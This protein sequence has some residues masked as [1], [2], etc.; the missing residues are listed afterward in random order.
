MAFEFVA[1]NGIIALNNTTITGS[2][3]TTGT[4]TS[5]ALIRSGST[6]LQI[7][8]G[9]GSVITAGTNI[10]I[11]GGT[12]SATG[13]GGGGGGISGSGVSGQLTYW[14]GTTSVTGSTTLTYSPTGALGL[15]ISPT[16]TAATNLARG[17]YLNPNLTIAAN[18]DVIVGL[19]ITP[20]YIGNVGTVNIINSGASYTAGTYTSV[21]LTGGNGTGAIATIVIAGGSIT[22]VTITAS[23]SG[24]YLG[25]VLSASSA[26][27]G[28]TGTGFSTSVA[29]FAYTGTSNYA[30]RIKGNQL[31]TSNS[32]YTTYNTTPS[33]RL[34]GISS[35]TNQ[36]ALSVWSNG[37]LAV[38]I[39]ASAASNVNG[40]VIYADNGF[41]APSYFSN[42]DSRGLKLNDGTATMLFQRTNTSGQI[43]IGISTYTSTLG[44]ANAAASPATNIKQYDTYILGSNYVPT[45]TINDIALYVNQPAGGL[46]IRI[47]GNTGNVG[48]GTN[49]DVTSSLLTMASTTKGFLPPRMTTAQKNAIGTPA[50]G[51]V[52]Y[53]TTLN[54]LAVYTGAAWETVTST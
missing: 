23:G 40:Y 31:I 9:D 14:N 33:I 35:S 46:G 39:N 28:G 32:S 34:F 47:F 6:N 53:D 45:S 49:T 36:H 11:S 51:L 4:I 24:Y 27:I 2:L 29:I 12:I 54:K 42:I 15:S 20:N 13:G 19:D 17:I 18:N 43:S 8:A 3:V 7:L 52:V 10:T 21:P 26:N 44:N 5:A 38:G 41:N 30:L 16:L 37:T 1:R 50:T 48:V 25:D 22:S